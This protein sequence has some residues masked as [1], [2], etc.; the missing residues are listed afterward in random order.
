MLCPVGRKF[1]QRGAA[2]NEGRSRERGQVA[3]ER[4]YGLMKEGLA[5]QFFVKASLYRSNWRRLTLRKED[6]DPFAEAGI[7][8]PSSLSL[9]ISAILIGIIACMDYRAIYGSVL[10]FSGVRSKC[11]AS[12]S[13]L[14]TKPARTTS[15]KDMTYCNQD[16]LQIFEDVIQCGIY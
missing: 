2:E 10:A 9:A 1:D 3:R 13:S 4:C 6:Q 16:I 7:A 12:R 8:E 5:I 14:S 11:Y 15:N